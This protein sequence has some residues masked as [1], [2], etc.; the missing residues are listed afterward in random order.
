MVQAKWKKYRMVDIEY[1]QERYYNGTEG[2]FDCIF[3]HG[4][5]EQI[6]KHIINELKNGQAQREIREFKKKMKSI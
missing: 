2:N 3:G 5:N 6:K 1:E 4:I